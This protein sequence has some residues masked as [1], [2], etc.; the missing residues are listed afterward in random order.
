MT[1]RSWG[2][3]LAAGLL[4]VTAAPGSAQELADFDYENLT[5]RGISVEGGWVHPSDIESTG[6][7]AARFDLGFLGPGFRIVPRIT[8]WSSQL[9]A[10][11]VARLA[12][13]LAAVLE[14]QGPLPG[15][16]DLGV[17]DRSDFV[18][19]VDGQFVWSLPGGVLSALGAGVSA[20][21]LNGSGEAVSGTFVEDLLDS[22]QAGLDVHGGLEYPLRDRLRL[23]GDV[24]YDL[25]DDI[26]SFQFGFGLSVL[27]GALAPGETRA[28]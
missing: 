11:E 16:L 21:F 17:I 18:V 14:E 12:N 5:F 3:V 25:T 13:R 27:W 20:H 6:Y 15:G 9:E 24:R 4:L 19:T 26:R 10:A 8:Y 22:V 2:A 7:V 28:P 23:Y 1:G